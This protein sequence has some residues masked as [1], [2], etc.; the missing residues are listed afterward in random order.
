MGE[1]FLR[2]DG[3]RSVTADTGACDL[4]HQG[5][6]LCVKTRAAAILATWKK[7][8]ASLV[9]TARDAV[10]ALSLLLIGDVQKRESDSIVSSVGRKCGITLRL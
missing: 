7:A 8:H 3:P 10:K 4:R 6:G 2:A 9:P 5:L 1:I